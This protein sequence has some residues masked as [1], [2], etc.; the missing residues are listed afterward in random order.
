MD[1]QQFATYQNQVATTATAEFTAPS[2]LAGVQ[3]GSKQYFNLVMFK[4]IS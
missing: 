2:K 1:L 3:I 4:T